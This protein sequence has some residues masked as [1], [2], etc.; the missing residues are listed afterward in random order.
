[1][2][3]LFLIEFYI[4]VNIEVLISKLMFVRLII[5]GRSSDVKAKHYQEVSKPVEQK[6]RWNLASPH[7]DELGLSVRLMTSEIPSLFFLRSL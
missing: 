6:A 5:G 3:L 7:H 2:G 4:G 1:M